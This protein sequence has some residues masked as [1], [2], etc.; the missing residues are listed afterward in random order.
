MFCSKCGKEIE[1]NS[2]FCKY[3]GKQIENVSNVNY[4]ANDVGRTS[5]A[6]QLIKC[7]NCG[8]TIES[9]QTHCSLCGTEIHRTRVVNSVQSLIG[10]LQSLDIQKNNE[11]GFKIK[12]PGSPVFDTISTV[13]QKKID[14]IRS[15]P[16]PNSVEDIVEFMFLAI[17]NINYHDLGGVDP[18]TPAL[19]ERIE[20]ARAWDAKADQAYQKA[21]FTMG[22]NPEFQKIQE[23]FD[24][25]ENNKKLARKRNMKRGGVLVLLIVAPILIMLLG[26][27]MIFFLNKLF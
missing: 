22:S 8:E 16:I 25:K 4:S 11:S 20:I 15:F 24:S 17:S 10:E 1:N 14:L 19:K 7:P 27:V 5:F 6:G 9:F 13:D 23:M 21:K 12:I 18:L 2:L 3:C 26:A